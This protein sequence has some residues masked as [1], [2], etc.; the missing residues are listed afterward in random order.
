M[1]HRT[2]HQEPCPWISPSLKHKASHQAFQPL[3]HKH[4]ATEE[5]KF[6]WLKENTPETNP[7]KNK[8]FTTSQKDNILDAQRILKNCGKSNTS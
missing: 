4:N 6:A 8:I 3:A 7:K 5:K 1:T 2:E